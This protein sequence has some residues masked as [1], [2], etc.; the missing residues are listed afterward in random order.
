MKDK[1]INFLCVI[2]VIVIIVSLIL[3]VRRYTTVEKNEEKLSNIVSEVYE[4][5]NTSEESTEVT[6]IQEVEIQGYSV[7]GVLKIEKIALEYPILGI[8]TNDA[9]KISITKFWGPDLNEIGNVTLAGHNNV[10]GRMF[11]KLKDLENGDII[12]LTDMTN[13]TIKYKVF[14]Q[15]I[16]DPNDLTCV[17]SV[18]PETRELTLLTCINRTKNRLV[19]KAREIENNN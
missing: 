19:T 10:Y 1:V 13:R 3:I 9:M 18:N 11:A 16:I 8:T 17:E 6:K 14:D 7:V 4:K 2:L 12:E 15:Y 5:I